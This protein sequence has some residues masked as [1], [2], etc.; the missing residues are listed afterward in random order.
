MP[1]M[2]PSKSSAGGETQIAAA[3]NNVGHRYSKYADGSTRDLFLF[4]GRHAYGDAKTW[5]TIKSK[6]LTLHAKDPRRLRVLDLGCGPG[7]WLRRV[8]AYA[9]RIGFTEII[10][11]GF[12]IADGQLN[13]ARALS[14]RL[15]SLDGVRIIFSHGDLRGDFGANE[16]DLC[17]CLYGVL[18]HIP[19]D[20]LPLVMD[21]IA[22]CSSGYF[23]AT[24]RTIGSTP[25]V[26]VDDVCSAVRFYQDNQNDRLDVEFSDGQ[27]TSFRSHL[28]SRDE[29][30]CLAAASFAIEDI[31]G[32]DLF[33]GR[34]ANDPR[35][36]PPE[37]QTT[38]RVSRELSQLEERYCRDSGFI[39]RA[40][41][42][43][44]VARNKGLRQT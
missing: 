29:L 13:H 18:N 11:N 44:L 17:L 43:L 14:H 36:N 32:L 40:A 38:S 24:V 7:T 16:H 23:L 20:E 19:R 42:L 41:H 3:Y 10:A 30:K 28:F 2:A 5:G 15:A 33:H 6:L 26:Y 4:E 27:R 12:D 34:F 31:R 1:V 9:H 22:L 25:T 39:D 37:H 35:W 8:V 21:R